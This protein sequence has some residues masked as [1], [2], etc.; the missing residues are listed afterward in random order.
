MNHMLAICPNYTTNSRHP[1]R[2]T[3]ETGSISQS[4]PFSNPSAATRALPA[5]QMTYEEKES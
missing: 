4:I 1:N 5:S 3:P 2:G